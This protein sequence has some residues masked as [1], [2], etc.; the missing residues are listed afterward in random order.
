M[1]EGSKIN[2]VQIS[3][4]NDLVFISFVLAGTRAILYAYDTMVN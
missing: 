4:V 3:T 2:R 1:V